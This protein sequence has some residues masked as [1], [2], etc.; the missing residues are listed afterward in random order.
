[1]NSAIYEGWVRHRRHDPIE[2]EFRYPLFM[3]YLDLAELPWALDP[4]PGWSA[5]RPAIARFRRSDYL[6]EA[7]R[8]LAECVREAV[9]ERSGIES[10]G[11]IRL[12]TNLRYFGHAFNPV[13]FYYCFDEAGERVDSVLAEVTNTPWGE[14]HSYLLGRADGVRHHGPSATGKSE[15]AASKVPDPSRVIRGEIDKAFH[16]SPLMGMEHTYD[17][18][19]TEPRERVQVH[20]DSRSPDADRSDFDATLSLERRELSSETTRRVLYR[21]PAMTTQVVAK[22]YWQSLRLWLKG[23]PYFPHPEQG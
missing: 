8:P 13:S 5:R 17:W 15:S 9:A 2:H 14:R 6:G 22:I 18:R 10:K 7:N 16:V 20:I 12:L 3:A 21:Y 4:F 11:P 1:M 23:A 19:S